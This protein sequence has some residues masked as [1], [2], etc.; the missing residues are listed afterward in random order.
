MVGRGHEHTSSAG[1]AYWKDDARRAAARIVRLD[2]DNKTFARMPISTLTREIER[3][4][5]FSDRTCAA[6]YTEVT[7]SLVAKANKRCH[8]R[9]LGVRKP[10][11][12]LEQAVDIMAAVSRLVVV[13]NLADV[14]LL[15]TVADTSRVGR[16]AGACELVTP[17]QHHVVAGI[18]LL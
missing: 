9:G 5:G 7:A 17:P 11:L 3:Q 18:L 15:A 16:S 12:K 6:F 4:G 8:K 1:E 2:V 14:D 13:N 10:E